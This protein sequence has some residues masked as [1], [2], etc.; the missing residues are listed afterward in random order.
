MATRCWLTN[1]FRGA[2]STARLVFSVVVLVGLLPHLAAAQ[3][4]PSVE[5]DPFSLSRQTRR[6]VADYQTLRKLHFDDMQRNA[7]MFAR[8]T[9]GKRP[10]ALATAGLVEW[11]NTFG[12]TACTNHGVAKSA[13][14]PL[15]LGSIATVDLNSKGFVF[16]GFAL[17]AV[18]RLQASPTSAQEP[19]ADGTVS[20]PTGLAS[21][22]SQQS[23]RRAQGARLLGVLILAAICDPT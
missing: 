18:D 13:L 9:A 2:S 21:V 5:T 7:S 19:G 8:Q 12:F 20:D 4:C 11:Q 15:M 17:L 1:T 10:W 14:N 16:E 22:S 6:I 3:T 23:M